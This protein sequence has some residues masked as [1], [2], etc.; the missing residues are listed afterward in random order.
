MQKTKTSFLKRQQWRIRFP[1]LLCI[2]IVFAYGVGVGHYQWPPFRLI[3]NSITSLPSWSPASENTAG[4]SPLVA[5]EPFVEY[6]G[7]AELLTHAFTD[8]VME[9][10]LYYSPITDIA[11]IRE[12]NDRIFMQ[13]HGFKTAFESMRILGAEQLP[14]PQ[15]A[16]PAVRVQ[17]SY[18]ERQHEAFAYGRLP[19]TC[20]G[21]GYASLIIP[22][23]GFNQSLGIAAGDNTNYHH[24]ILDA[25][26]VSGEDIFTLIK[27]NEDFLAWHDGYGGKLSGDFIW[28]WHLN[29]GGSYSV[30]YLV[31]SLAITKW[32]QAC[33]GET[34]VAGLSQGGAAALIN[35]LQ[36]RPNQA[37]IASGHSV[38]NEH[39]EWSGHNQLIGVPGYAELAK[40]EHLIDQL[41]NSPTQWLFSWGRAESDIYRIEAEE[42]RTAKIIRKLPNITIAIHDDGHVFPK[43]SIQAFLTGN[44]STDVSP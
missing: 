12:A 44:T 11:E 5:S 2:V 13:R 31:Q 15:N 29:R 39:V 8:P 6:L 3:Q 22:G 30:S 27:P 38:I 33:Y 24:G 25:L 17:F 10:E 35:A 36:S 40:P 26:S 41:Q 9:A 23:S 28:N 18:Q 37:I 14:R 43:K 16:E 32:M 21:S 1:L 19:E 7:E 34:L 42:Q 4:H 20:D